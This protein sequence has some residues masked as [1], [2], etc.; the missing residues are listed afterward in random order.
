M[1]EEDQSPTSAES[2]LAPLAVAST[3]DGP[4]GPAGG[5]S[6]PSAGE[7]ARATTG[8]SR[9]DFLE[10]VGLVGGLVLRVADQVRASVQPAAVQAVAETFTFPLAL[11]LAVFLFL[12]VQH[13]LDRRDP[14][15]R[16]GPAAGTEIVIPF[17]D[18]GE[19]R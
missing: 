4:G 5:G 14:K 13:R 12:F 9:I 15:L 2:S 8:V 18:E 6:E 11:M 10:P 19:I 17:V 7:P 3:G 1:S 16:H